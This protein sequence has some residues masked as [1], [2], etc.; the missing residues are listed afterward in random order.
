[1][2]ARFRQIVE[3]QPGGIAR[4][5][6]EGP[7]DPNL[8]G[9]MVTTGNS[10]V[11]DNTGHGGDCE[12]FSV[13]K[14][15]TSG[16]R[17]NR[18]YG[19]TSTDNW[20]NN[21]LCQWFRQ[22]ANGQHLAVSGVPSEAKRCTDAVNRT[23][24][25]RPIA[26]V[27]VDAL[28][29]QPAVRRLSEQGNVI[30]RTLREY[31]SNFLTWTFSKRQLIQDTY[32]MIY[33][34]EALARR[35]EE[36]DRLYNSSKGLRRTVHHGDWSNQVHNPSVLVQSTYDTINVR[37]LTRTFVRAKTHV[38]WALDRDSGIRPTPRQ[39]RALMIQ[40]LQGATIDYSTLWEILPW[41]WLIDWFGNVGDVLR[42]TRNVIPARLVGVYP[43][44]HTKTITTW[45][46]KSETIRGRPTTISAGIRE[47]ESK[48]R[49]IGAVALSAQTELFS[50]GHLGVLAALGASRL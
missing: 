8:D 44:L 33:L 11:T 39:L 5:N 50:A 45:P 29:I 42:T 48:T 17:L 27:P 24:P 1:M 46:A 25:S 9:G 34:Q 21:Y 23:N 3:Q 47:R 35:A 18:S 36:V 43:M 41:T 13:S 15:T 38:R 28:E 2:P 22:T 32:K 10:N 20:F 7:Y 12:P 19:G 49:S 14:L 4:F 6:W 37:M 16:G 31:G 26:D 40:S 30:R